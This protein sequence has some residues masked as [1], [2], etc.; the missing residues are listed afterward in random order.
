M[1]RAERKHMKTKLLHEKDG[2]KTFILVFDKGDEV[3]EGIL[4][5]ARENK[6]SASRFSAI[7]ALS[8]AVLG[9][10]NR[11]M[12]SYEEIPVNE[13]VEVASLIGNISLADGA[14]R[15]HAHAVVSKKDGTCVGGHLIKAQVWPTLELMLI[16]FPIELHREV[17]DESGL[18]LIRI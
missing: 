5:F 13:Q 12:K 17:D 16:E 3:I 8:S 6:L 18:A 4:T 1:R 10:F 9:F 15:I 14:T 2:Q 11:E 7:G